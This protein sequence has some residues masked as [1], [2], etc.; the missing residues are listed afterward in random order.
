MRETALGATAI[1]RC[2]PHGGLIAQI[3]MVSWMVIVGHQC[4]N[5]NQ[6]STGTDNLCRQWNLPYFIELIS[7]I[8]SLH[9]ACGLISLAGQDFETSSKW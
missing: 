2:C 1:H 7:R 3:Q 6:Q 9:Y 8:M 4:G 5:F